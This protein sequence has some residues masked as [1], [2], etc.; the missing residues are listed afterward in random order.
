MAS[1]ALRP[2]RRTYY[3]DTSTLS[4]AFRGGNPKF[5]YDSDPAEFADLHELVQSIAREDNLCVSLMHFKELGQ[6]PKSDE[7]SAFVEWID[8]IDFV[9]MYGCDQVQAL[10]D[11]RALQLAVGV[12]APSPVALYAP[13]LLTS[14][15]TLQ[16]TEA[17]EALHGGGRSL[18]K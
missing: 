17:A 14:F 5:R 18:P 12:S 9:T 2:G 7:L 1:I 6:W 3:L 16:M 15:R 4:Y 10:E 8:A 13:S 11:Q